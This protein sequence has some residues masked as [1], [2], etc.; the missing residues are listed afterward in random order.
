MY[1]KIIYGLLII[2]VIAGLTQGQENK[3]IGFTTV[4]SAD[5]SNCKIDTP[6]NNR[7][8]LQNR[9]GRNTFSNIGSVVKND[10]LINADSTGGYID[11]F[12]PHIALA[13]NGD[14]IVVRTERED[15][16]Y[17]VYAQC[18]FANGSQKGNSFRVNDDAGV[19][20][21]QNPSITISPT[22]A[23]IIVWSDE[24][25]GNDDIYMQRYDPT[26]KTLGGNVKINDDIDSSGKFCPQIAQSD[27]GDICIVWGDMRNGNADIYYQRYDHNGCP[28]GANKRVNDNTCTSIQTTPDLAVSSNGDVFITWM[29]QRNGNN[30][31][32][33][34]IMD[35]LDNPLSGNFKVNDDTGTSNQEYPTIASS[36]SG[37]FCIAWG[38]LRNSHG[39]IYLQ[40]YRSDGNSIGNNVK[41]NQVGN[42]GGPTYEHDISMSGDGRCC[43][44][45]LG[46]D[47]AYNINAQLFDSLGIPSGAN[48][49]VSEPAAQYNVGYPA[50]S[51]NKY[52]SFCMAWWDK[53][54]GDWD[55]YSQ[56]YDGC[57]LPIGANQKLNDDDGTSNQ[58]YP[59]VSI[60]AAGG[61]CIAWDDCRNGNADIYCQFYNNDGTTVSS[62]YKVNDDTTTQNQYNS[63]SSWSDDGTICIAWEDYRN[64]KSDIYCQLFNS[65]GAAEGNNIKVN[66]GSDITDQGRPDVASSGK[67]VFV[68]VW[69]GAKVYYRLFNSTGTMLS[70]INIAISDGM[71]PTVSMAADGSFCIACMYCNDHHYDIIVRRYDAAGKPLSD[72]ITANDYN[73]NGFTF[74]PSIAMASDGSFGVTWMDNRNN[75]MD[76]Y[77]QLYD[78]FDGPLGQNIK[79]NDD[80]SKDTNWLPAIAMDPTGKSI[81]TWVDYRES[82]GDPEIMSQKIDC[83][84][85]LVGTNVVVND[86]SCGWW[87][88]FSSSNSVACNLDNIIFAWSDNRRHKG[89]DIY[90]KIVQWD[91]DVDPRPKIERLFAVKVFPNPSRESL[92]IR[93]ALL[94][95]SPVKIYIY[96]ILGQKVRT[97]QYKEVAWGNH[98]ELWDCKNEMGYQVSSG[99]YLIHIE[100]GENQMKTKAVIIK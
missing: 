46:Y 32:Y 66:D 85:K 56:M 89:S 69:Q 86:D 77:A 51:M 42:N 24:R 18:Y 96:N 31:V 79:I 36:D 64:G 60:S 91:L 37:E 88:Q 63:A 99:V 35:S 11:K 55:F 61:H 45:W 73:E 12:D 59:C 9:I 4:F 8:I 26:G 52:G 29:D 65:Y 94:E 25:T 34:Q 76:I 1:A 10:F 19:S 71:Y 74:M 57:G 49:I 58:G 44:T 82:D 6:V 38:D 83:W 28:V 39:D 95:R 22:G 72:W 68:A 7:A 81:I 13:D 80:F 2:A 14:F 100:S 90:G 33:A 41:I 5:I 23:F 48:F 43:V 78:D 21:Q 97:F 84:G 47:T 92:T 70:D 54:N 53:R 75:G 15:R 27:M 3:A 87:H 93:Y 67:G 40:R 98:D 50:V 30:D 20:Y 16:T 62:N 17:D